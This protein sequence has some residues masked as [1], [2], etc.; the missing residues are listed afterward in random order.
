MARPRAG[1]GGSAPGQGSA[2]FGG[3]GEE[4]RLE[5]DVLRLG[6]WALE[7]VVR[8]RRNLA[9][10]LIMIMIIA[11]VPV[12]LLPVALAGRLSGSEY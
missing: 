4:L 9:R 8:C 3:L 11:A 12:G 7:V 5:R 1:P 2:V 6:R 10:K